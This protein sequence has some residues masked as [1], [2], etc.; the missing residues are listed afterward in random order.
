MLDSNTNLSESKEQLAFSIADK[1]AKSP[2]LSGYTDYREFLKD[3]YL[4]K[5]KTSSSMVRAYSYAIFSAAANIKSP[6]YLKLII[7]AKRNLSEDMINKFATALAFNKNQTN[8]FRA[9]VLF[10]QAKEPLLRNQYLKVLADIRVKAKIK[11]GEIAASQYKQIPSWVSYA[12]YALLDQKDVQFTA[13]H[14]FDLL[15]AKATKDEIKSCLSKLEEGGQIEFNETT[16]VYEK[17]KGAVKEQ[18][19][20]VVLVRKLQSE[21]IYLGLESLFE[22]Q[23][24]DRE[25]GA[26]TM[27]LTKE[28]YQKLMFD[29]RHFRKKIYKDYLFSREATKGEKLYQLNFQLFGVSK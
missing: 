3:Y 21:F 18:A 26:L 22:D 14:L 2:D 13:D 15:K 20:P 10:N 29:V 27:S 7:E 17:T 4:Y 23:K 25:F 1:K 16:K 9:L 19:I 28:E 11:N 6:N 12:L 5:I 24:S 8:E